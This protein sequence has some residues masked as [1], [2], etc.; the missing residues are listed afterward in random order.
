VYRR[1]HSE[2]G[3]TLLELFLAVALFGLLATMAIPAYRGYVERVR[4]SQA[5]T[6][7]GG[8]QL[9][10]YRWNLSTGGFP[11]TLLAAGLDGLLDPW[12]RP[13]VYLN[14]A[15]AD[16]NDVRKDKNLH[17]LNTDFDLY[18][19]GAD[20]DSRLPLTAR[21]SRDDIL[22]ANNGAFIGRAENYN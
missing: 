19:L 15:T 9:D 22:R 7:I 18:S 2:S 16:Q 14:I 11:E 1:A 13:Y 21:A 5:I 6:D 20:G 8:L 4:E 17:P 10:L 3:F 12:G